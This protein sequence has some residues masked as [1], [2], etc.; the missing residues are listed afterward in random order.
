[1]WDTIANIFLNIYSR[2]ADRPVVRVRVKRLEY[3]LI[4]N[5]ASSVLV[6][7]TP[8]A[9]R[10]YAEVAFAHRGKATTI[11]GLTL[12]IDND[13]KLEATGFSPLKLEHG[14]YHKTAV[15]FPVEEQVVIR[16]GDFEIQ[17]TDAFDKVV[18]R[19]RGHFPIVPV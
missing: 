11:K 1:M 9:S 5:D 15:V 12:I 13:L 16:K 4:R 19:L 14:D 17:A 7:I 2:W 6:V 8:Y 3:N 10:Y 18:D